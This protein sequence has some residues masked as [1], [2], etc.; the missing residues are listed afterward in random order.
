[1]HIS[2]GVLSAPVLLTGWGAAATGLAVALKKT[3]PEEISRVAMLSAAIFLISLVRVPVGPSSV[4]LVLAGIM[5][6]LLGVRVIPAIFIALLL[7]AL[8][9]QFGGLAVLGVNTVNLSLAGLTGFAIYK[10]M[11]KKIPQM[12]KSFL[13]G[14]TAVIVASIMLVSAM[15]L[16]D[17]NFATTAQLIFAANIPLAI[18]EGVVTMFILLFLKKVLPEYV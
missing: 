16:S 18:V 3:A 4:H 2:E 6:V 1:M 13:A 11:P 12:V 17:G 15:F 14:F 8:L 7:Q 10:Y 9:F 5:G